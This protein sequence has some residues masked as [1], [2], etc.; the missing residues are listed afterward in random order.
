MGFLKFSAFSPLHPLTLQNLHIKRRL[1]LYRLY[2]L[3][4]NKL[5]T[6]NGNLREQSRPR[7]GAAERMRSLNRASQHQKDQVVSA[8]HEE[9]E[10]R[11]AFVIGIEPEVQLASDG[12]LAQ[13]AEYRRRRNCLLRDE[14]RTAVSDSSAVGLMAVT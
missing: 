7:S 5:H 3:S 9:G 13:T 4:S 8:G 10:V 14:S 6:E 12:L 1:G 11:T 2:R